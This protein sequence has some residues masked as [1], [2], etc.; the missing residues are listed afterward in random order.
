MFTCERGVFVN[1]VPRK[2][3]TAS[4][5]AQIY[6]RLQKRFRESDLS[7]GSKH[8]DRFKGIIPFGH[9]GRTAWLEAVLIIEPAVLVAWGWGDQ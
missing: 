2:E 4:K 1:R 8:K 7:N 9:Q 5:L 3:T 6:T